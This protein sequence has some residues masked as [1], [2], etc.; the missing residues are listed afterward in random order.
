MPS[1]NLVVPDKLARALRTCGFFVYYLAIIIA[2][3]WI[4]GRGDT[5]TAPF[6]YQGF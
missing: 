3:L 4:Y 6:V 2:L 5:P 1:A